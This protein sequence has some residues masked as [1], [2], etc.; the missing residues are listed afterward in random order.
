MLRYRLRCVLLLVVVFGFISCAPRQ[1]T[2]TGEPITVSPKIKS[3]RAYNEA[4]DTFNSLVRNYNLQFKLQT[5]NAV[6][7]KWVKEINPK[8]E[9]VNTALDTWGDTIAGTPD[10]YTKEKLYMDA[11]KILWSLLLSQG[12]IEIK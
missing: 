6:K 2:V 4:L 7:V 8:I 10:S 12:V 11:Y 1:T 9:I 3:L 5:D